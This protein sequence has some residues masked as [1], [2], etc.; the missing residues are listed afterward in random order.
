MKATLTKDVGIWLDY[1]CLP[2]GERNSDE[3][4][5]FRHM[6]ARNCYLATSSHVITIWPNESTPLK[7][8]W[9]IAEVAMSHWRVDVGAVAFRFV[10]DEL[11]G[12]ACNSTDPV[13]EFRALGPEVLSVTT[14]LEQVTRSARSPDE[15]DKWFRR[16]E[17]Q[18]T[19]ERDLHIIS[20]S[21][22]AATASLRQLGRT[23]IVYKGIAITAESLWWSVA[24]CFFFIFKPLAAAAL[25]AA[26]RVA[27]GGDFP[28]LCR[29]L[30]WVLL[31]FCWGL[32]NGIPK[33]V[34]LLLAPVELIRRMAVST[35]E[36]RRAHLV[37]DAAQEAFSQTF[38]LTPTVQISASRQSK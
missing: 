20:A 15:I 28:G 8:A 26:D 6:L 34:T 13:G 37:E 27:P 7:R 10:E 9:C 25:S 14:A 11:K 36:K 22:F 1:S 16:N 21:L 2:Q 17:I 12:G 3:N 5:Y 23:A 29:A 32:F 24:F 4:D 19:V 35:I 31:T 30:V 33:I 18:T 38:Q